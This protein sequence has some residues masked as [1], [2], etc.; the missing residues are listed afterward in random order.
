MTS[1]PPPQP[2]RAVAEPDAMTAGPPAFT[3]ATTRAL[4]RLS[5]DEREAILSRP[6]TDESFART[7][8]VH[9]DLFDRLEVVPP[10]AR[11]ES[12]DG[13]ARVAFW[14]AERGKYLDASAKLLRGL[15]A[16]AYLL[17]EL[18]LGMARS[19]QAHTVRELA[20]R[21]GAGYAFG[22]EFLELGLGDAWER[23]WHAGQTNEAG[24]HGAAI[25]S[26]Y[27]LERPALVRLE[28]D[29]RWFD[30]ANGERR[31]GG[32]I[33]LLATLWIEGRP[34]TLVDVHFESHSDPPGRAAQMRRLLDAIDTYAEGRPALIGG[35][36]N[37]S[38]ASRGWARGTGQKPV[39]PDERLLDPVPFE[40][41]FEVA[42]AR[43]YDWR[44]CNALGVPTQ[45]TRPDGTPPPP[46][47]KIDWFFSHGLRVSDPRTVP[48]VDDAGVAISDH[49]ILVVTIR[50]A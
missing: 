15:D 7:L 43:G 18:D 29:G 9:D 2:G 8:A 49:E 5:L 19:G 16:A 23:G 3:H 27:P 40:P 38:T 44:A 11:K 10:P 13:P 20:L 12:L 6:V 35:D 24:L 32:R 22:V 4:R 30:G 17:C 28:S 26:P 36:F 46:F 47:G 31:L 41:L 34:V 21:L 25:L 45:R 1:A 48:A 42:A 50:P 33:A 14:N 37:T 39:L